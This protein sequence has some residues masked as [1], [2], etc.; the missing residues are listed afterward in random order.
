MNREVFERTAGQWRQ[1]QAAPHAADIP[2]CGKWLLFPGDVQLAERICL[3]A[4]HFGLVEKCKH[5]LDGGV[6]CLYLDAEDDA[7]HVRLLQWLIDY[8]LIPRKRNGELYNI[9]FKLD[10]LTLNQ[11]RGST[12]NLE[13]YF[14]LHG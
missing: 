3:S 14:S 9:A 4:V 5:A 11:Q 8:D 1:Y 6:V 2:N 10:A 12:F 7:G 13:K